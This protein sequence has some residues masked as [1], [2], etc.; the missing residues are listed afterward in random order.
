M[1]FY[2]KCVSFQDGGGAK[3]R[4]NEGTKERKNDGAKERMNEGMNG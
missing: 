2:E 4:R 1:I 3:E